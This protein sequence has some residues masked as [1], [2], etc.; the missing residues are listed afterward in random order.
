MKRS[1]FKPRK[2]KIWK[3]LNRVSKS[4][5]RRAARTIP[6]SVKREVRERSFGR[7]ERKGCQRIA[8][9]FHHILARSQG[10]KHTAVNLKH[11]CR[12]DHT[13]CK[14]RPNEAIELGL[15]IPYAGYTT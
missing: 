5:H 3:S 7:C 12:P 9:D 2:G 8:V 10:G 11:L 13:L 15:V 14:D 6:E 4:P 1:A